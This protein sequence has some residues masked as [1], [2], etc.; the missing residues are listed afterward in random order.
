MRDHQDTECLQPTRTG[1]LAALATINGRDAAGR[2]T[3]T[4]MQKPENRSKLAAILTYH[5]VPGPLTAA[6][7]AGLTSVKTV[8]GQS[9]NIAVTDGAVMIDDAR[10]VKTDVAASDGVIHAIDAVLLPAA[11]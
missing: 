7:V 5:V 8:N 4:T 2:A 9:V 11:R 1:G 6:E 10:V 3:M